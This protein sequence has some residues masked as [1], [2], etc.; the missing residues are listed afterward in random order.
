VILVIWIIFVS[1][2][3]IIAQEQLATAQAYRFNWME[4]TGINHEII[5][6]DQRIP[7]HIDRTKS[8]LLA[9]DA[10]CALNYGLRIYNTASQE[11][12]SKIWVIGELTADS[13]RDPA[14]GELA[15]TFILSHWF[16]E[17]PFI[18]VTW[19]ESSDLPSG[20]YYRATKERF[21]LT[22]TDFA[23]WFRKKYPDFTPQPYV[24]TIR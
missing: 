20:G 4:S 11:T 17:S 3:I 8:H 24:H 7:I 10:L 15:T 16:I 18:G 6:D 12:P 2:S 19:Q 22:T 1:H 13:Y 21:M 5:Q 14:T 9:W 23:E